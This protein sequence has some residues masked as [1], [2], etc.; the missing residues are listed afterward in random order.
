[1]PSVPGAAP[2]LLTVGAPSG[3]PGLGAFLDLMDDQAA[4]ATG[5]QPVLPKRQDDAEPGNSLPDQDQDQSPSTDDPALAWL[6]AGMQIVAPQP[7]PVPLPKFQFGS[8]PG[9]VI[10]APAPQDVSAPALM[11]LAADVAPAAGGD[12]KIARPQRGPAM[13]N[14]GGTDQPAPQPP[15]AGFVQPL[16]ATAPADTLATPAIAVPN[17]VPDSAP[18]V[19]PT[20][21]AKPREPM[22]AVADQIRQPTPLTTAI[23]AARTV[24]SSP[25]T[26]FAARTTAALPAMFALAAGRHDDRD[27]DTVASPAISGATL[28]QPADATKLIAQP[29]EMQRQTLDMSRQ[30]WPQKMID[31]IETLRDNADANDTSIRLKPDALGKIDVSI[32]SHADGAVSVKFTAEQPAARTLI[33]D[34]QP[35]L[36]AA[37]EARGI[38]LSGTSVDLAGSGQG[39]GDQPRPQPEANRNTSNRLATSGDDITADSTGRIA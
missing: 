23:N 5:E 3:V 15:M 17:A 32:R 31:R 35:Q 11:Q 37:A 21:E 34:A 2:S 9:S 12:A 33:A 7:T 24:A 13:I 25:V 1:M 8:A 39:G 16:P 20:A 26:A 14:S 22:P 4:P 38:R 29:G 36:A 6:M 18:T 30:D 19:Q 10:A 27:R 28:L